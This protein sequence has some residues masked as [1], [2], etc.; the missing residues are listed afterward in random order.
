MQSKSRL[1]MFMP[2]HRRFLLPV[3]CNV[4]RHIHISGFYIAAFHLSRARME[5]RG[6]GPNRRCELEGSS[7]TQIFPILSN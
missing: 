4:I 7:Y 3:R 2:P 1:L 5:M 6:P